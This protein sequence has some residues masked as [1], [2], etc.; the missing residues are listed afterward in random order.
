MACRICDSGDFVCINCTKQLCRKHSIT[1]RD[2]QERCINCHIL[3][4]TPAKWIIEHIRTKE[5]L[6]E[7]EYDNTVWDRIEDPTKRS[8]SINWVPDAKWLKM[9]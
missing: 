1:G 9:V 4:N 7:A 5:W 2:T 3:V 6:I 8:E